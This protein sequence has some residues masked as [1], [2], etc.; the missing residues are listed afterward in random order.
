[1]LKHLYLVLFV[2]AFLPYN[3]ENP[4]RNV[5]KSTKITMTQSTVVRISLNYNGFSVDMYISSVKR[6]FFTKEI[7]NVGMNKKM[8]QYNHKLVSLLY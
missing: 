4:S 1:M 3:F 6:D 5:P 7:A 2:C 8:F